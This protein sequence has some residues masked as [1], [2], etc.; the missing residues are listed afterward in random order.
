MKGASSVDVSERA[1]V[2]LN[3]LLTKHHD[4]RD[5]VALLEPTYAESV[6]RYN[7]SR[8]AIHREKWIAHYRNMERLHRNL[9]AEHAEKA[10]RLYEEGEA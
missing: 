5:G 8:T 7:A 2:E 10:A 4:P 3:R 6:R 9:A 1:D